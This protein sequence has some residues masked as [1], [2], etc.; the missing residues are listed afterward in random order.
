MGNT[1]RNTRMYLA[2]DPQ[3][4]YFLPLGFILYFDFL[5]WSKTKTDSF[6]LIFKPPNWFVVLAV[7][8]FLWN[9]FF[10]FYHAIK[11]KITQLSQTHFIKFNSIFQL[12]IWQG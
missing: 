2:T 3:W 11:Y 10:C 1:K 12:V 4:I 5:F 7:E 9:F 6:S 8:L